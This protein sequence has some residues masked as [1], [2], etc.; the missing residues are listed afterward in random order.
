V[1]P[2]G[3]STADGQHHGFARSRRVL[4]VARQFAGQAPRG[5][6]QRGHH[7]LQLVGVDDR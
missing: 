3:R 2:S 4:R 5:D 7:R 1:G 6:G